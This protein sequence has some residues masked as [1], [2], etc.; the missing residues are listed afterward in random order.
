MTKLYT[1]GY[2][3][4]SPDEF[5]Q[6][7]Q[8]AGIEKVLDIRRTPWMAPGFAR[9]SQLKQTLP[10]VG[11]AYYSNGRLA[12]SNKLLGAW[13]K[14]K[15]ISW[16]EY[17]TRFH[18]QMTRTGAVNDLDRAFFD[19]LCCLLCMEPTPEHCHRRLVAELLKE[20]WPELEIEH[21]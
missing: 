1:I 9:G 7:L 12:P 17:E 18:E 15:G 8:Q 2:Q 21:L 13:D 11:I 3:H 14:D 10:Q 16:Q 6:A 19:E 4:K 5:L 20:R